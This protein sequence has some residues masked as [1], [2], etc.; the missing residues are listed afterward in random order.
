MTIVRGT[1]YQPYRIEYVDLATLNVTQLSDLSI[2][3]DVSVF[4][5]MTKFLLHPS[6]ALE[7]VSFLFVLL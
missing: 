4:E 3:R 5:F 7:Y 2:I 6:S 1:T